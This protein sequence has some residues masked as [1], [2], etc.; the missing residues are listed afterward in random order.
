MSEQAKA[1]SFEPTHDEEARQ[2]FVGA[3]KGYANMALEPRLHRLYDDVIAPAAEAE[4]GRKPS[5]RADAAAWMRPHPLYRLWA[6]LTYQSQEMLWDS[7]TATTHRTGADQEAKANDLAQRPDRLGT[8][9][10]DP[11]LKVPPPVSTV[12]IHRQPGGYVRER[13]PGDL[14]AAL[15]YMGAIEIYRNAKAMGTG[16]KAGSDA[17]G[18]LMTDIVLSR[19]PDVAPRAVLD[20]GCGTGEQTLAYKRRFPDA[21]VMGLDCS[22]PF[23]RFTHAVAEGAGLAVHAYQGDA[24]RTGLD[25]ESVELI[26]S[27]I[28]FHETSSAQVPRILSECYR[29]LRPG[30]VCL[31]LDVPYQ[32]GHIPLAA[33]V[34]NDWQVRHNN[35]PFWT[36]FADLDMRRLLT[37]AGFDDAEVVVDYEQVGKGDYFIFGGR[38]R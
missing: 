29:L 25:D 6:S 7:V 15:T 31:H 26:V 2:N 23:V 4:T 19:F 10:L 12:E 38:K 36:G 27:I 33:Q 21:E 8:L 5:N 11:A 34:T 22:A 14:S 17:L 1:V 32:P 24:Q 13:Y 9:T 3:L 16:Q 30:G 18:Q 37:E 28:L 20:L 35:E